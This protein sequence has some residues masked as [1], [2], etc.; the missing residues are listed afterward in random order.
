MLTAYAY[1]IDDYG[2]DQ[3]PRNYHGVSGGSTLPRMGVADDA[4]GKS[5]LFKAVNLS[6]LTTIALSVVLG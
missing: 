3:N 6:V 4:Q 2:M 5:T 1:G